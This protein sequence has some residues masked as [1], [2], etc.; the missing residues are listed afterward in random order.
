MPPAP[1]RLRHRLL[2]PADVEEALAFLPPWLG[3]PDAMRAALPALWRALLDQP[4]FNADVIEDLARPPG[5][6]LMG[7][8]MSVA[9]DAAWC[10]RLAEAPPAYATRHLYGDLLSGRTQLPGDAALAR[11]NAADGVSFMVLHYRQHDPGVDSPAALS[12]W[13]VGLSAMRSAHA[14]HRVRQLYQ[15]AWGD[16]RQVMHSVGMHQRTSRSEAA[17]AAPLPELYGLSREEALRLLPGAHLRDVFEH[18]APLFGFSPAQRRLL[19]RAVFDES[20]ADI[21]RHLASTPHTLKKHWRA[22]HARASAALPELFGPSAADTPDGTRGP[23]KKRALVS[24]L[25]Q[26]PEELRPYAAERRSRQPIKA[27]PANDKATLAGSG[28]GASA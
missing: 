2:Q 11:A 25:R 23:E 1:F 9:L 6:R 4:G 26:H 7:L 3:L 15:E 13:S 16:E 5:Q 8:G 20:D 14:G 22:I 17:G 19:R 21:A 28:T 10:R 12:L 24:Y 18:H 27:S